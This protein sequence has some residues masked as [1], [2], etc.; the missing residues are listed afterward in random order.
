M[1]KIIQYWYADGDNTI[2]ETQLP[3]NTYNYDYVIHYKLHADAG[4][5]LYNP[6]TKLVEKTVIIFP[7]EIQ[8]WI[9]LSF[10]ELQKLKVS[11]N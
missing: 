9:E 8:D 6:H 10:E 7:Y 2:I 5:M 4:K 3:K 11:T 1:K